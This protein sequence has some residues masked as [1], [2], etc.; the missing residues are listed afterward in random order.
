VLGIAW[1]RGCTKLVQHASQ[2][3]VSVWEG[4]VV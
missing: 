3:M 1:D 4:G 2:Q